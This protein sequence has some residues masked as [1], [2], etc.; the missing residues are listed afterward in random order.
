MCEDVG[1]GEHTISIFVNGYYTGTGSG[2]VEVSQPDGSF[3]TGGGYILTST[4]SP[5]GQY[6]ADPGSRMNYGFNVKYNKNRTN[7]QGHMNV[8]F[9]RTVSG[10]LRTYQIKANAMDS[11]GIAL[12][13]GSVGCPGPPSGACWGLAEFRSKASLTD[14][15]NPLAPISLGG[16]LTLNV[17]LTDKGEPGRNDSIGVTLWQGGTLL[18]SSEWNGAKTLERII[19]GGNLVVH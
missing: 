2:M 11:L 3:I 15:T 8:I 14:I 1:L 5:A 16:N 19:E 17:T 7:L 18:F 6:A 12:K 10:V 4:S 13:N 9:R